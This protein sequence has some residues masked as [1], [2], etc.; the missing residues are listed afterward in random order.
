MMFDEYEG[1]SCPLCE[2]EGL[3]LGTLGHLVWLRCRDCGIDFNVTREAVAVDLPS[4]A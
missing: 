4:V 3:L 2:G 1:P